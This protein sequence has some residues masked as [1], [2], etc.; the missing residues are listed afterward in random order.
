M[1]VAKTLVHKGA[2][3]CLKADSNSFGFFFYEIRVLKIPLIV[4]CFKRF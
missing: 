3:T 1:P 2:F 4:Y